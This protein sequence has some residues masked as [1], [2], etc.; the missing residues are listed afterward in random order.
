[1]RKV[2]ENLWYAYLM[3]NPVEKN[4]DKKRV[5]DR[6]EAIEEELRA[7]LNGV[8]AEKLKMYDDCLSDISGITEK[9]AFIKGIRFNRLLN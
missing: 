1:M 7:S 6:L 3:E 2:L 4:D 8:K 9:E 5:L